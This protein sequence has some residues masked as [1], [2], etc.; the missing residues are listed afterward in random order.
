MKKAVI[1]VLLTVAVA[2]AVLLFS[3]CSTKYNYSLQIDV[4]AI[5]TASLTAA[6]Q[7]TV[8][9]ATEEPTTDEYGQ[10]APET[11]TKLN[12]GELTPE[13][14]AEEAALGY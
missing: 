3:S 9:P 14:L 10:Y 13:E 5:P 7:T 11:T 4:P 1:A 2:A 12:T 8:P 6:A